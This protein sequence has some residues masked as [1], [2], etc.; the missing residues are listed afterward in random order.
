MSRT[1]EE[2][3]YLRSIG[4]CTFCGKNKVVDEGHSYCSSCRAYFRELYQSRKEKCKSWR[5][6]RSEKAK[7]EER[8]RKRA[9]SA[10]RYR[11]RKEKGL[12]ISCGKYRAMNGLVRCM[13]CNDKENARQYRKRREAQNAG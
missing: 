9:Y 1:K 4:F 10:K 8:A 12:C 2:M 5:E 13:I 11:E 3:D 6:N 7:A